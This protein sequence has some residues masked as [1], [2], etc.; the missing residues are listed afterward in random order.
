MQYSSL[1]QLSLTELQENTG[2]GEP[3]EKESFEDWKD[4]SFLAE[5]WL[6]IHP[7]HRLIFAYISITPPSP[8]LVAGTPP[9]EMA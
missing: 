5:E 7:G 4:Y 3:E 2:E 8:A 1:A 9:P 6:P